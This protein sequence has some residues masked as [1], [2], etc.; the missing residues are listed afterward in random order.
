MSEFSSLWDDPAEQQQESQQDGD[1]ASV[2]LETTTTVDE[3][4]AAD[5]GENPVAAAIAASNW[6]RDDVQLALQVLNLLVLFY[7]TYHWRKQNV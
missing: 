2:E 6:S 4:A 3:T 5:S 1:S 7:F